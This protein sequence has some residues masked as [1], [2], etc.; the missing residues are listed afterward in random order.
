MHVHV[1]LVLLNELKSKI[2]PL[3][4]K[5]PNGEQGHF[6]CALSLGGLGAC[7]P[8]KFLHFGLSETASGAL[9]GT[10]LMLRLYLYFSNKD[11]HTGLAMALQV[12][13]V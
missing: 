5:F 3:F 4:R 11:D 2:R 8:R 10:N 7:S 13:Q 1:A 12:C 9:S 6:P